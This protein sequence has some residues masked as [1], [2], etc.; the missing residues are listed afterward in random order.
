MRSEDKTELYKSNAG[1]PSPCQALEIMEPLPSF[2]I[3]GTIGALEIGVFLSYILFGV[4]TM[5]AYIYYGRF[6]DDCLYMKI[7]VAMV[8]TLEL[9]H[10]ISTGHSLYAVSVSAFGHPE[11]FVRAPNSM[12]VALL[13]SGV[14]IACVQG[15]FA[16]RIYR[17]SRPSSFHV[18]AAFCRSCACWVVASCSCSRSA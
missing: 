12:A 15:F 1:R 17:F 4:E 8:W 18:C 2:D 3:D 14:I 10:V 16:A 5:Q 7:L 11:R 6:P 13:L 9:G